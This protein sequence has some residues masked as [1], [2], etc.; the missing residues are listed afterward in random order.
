MC[1]MEYNYVYFN[2]IWWLREVVPDTDFRKP[3][4]DG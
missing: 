2:S 3:R 1:I 4:V